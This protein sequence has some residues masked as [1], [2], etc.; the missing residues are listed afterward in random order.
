[1]MAFRDVA[2]VGIV[3]FAMGVGFLSL[4][5][6]FNT[7]VD[8]MLATS[9]INE[10]P[11]TVG[12]LG[13]VKGV[14]ERLDWVVFGIFMGLV[15]AMLVSAWFIPGHPIFMFVY[16][17]AV[18]VIVVVGAVLSNA[19]DTFSGTPPIDGSKSSFGITNNLLNNL[20]L[21]LSVVG[22]LGMII[23]FSKPGDSGGF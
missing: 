1:M 5:Y 18:L 12:V 16:F 15:L 10:S 4:H 6:M 23:L 14:T 11:S 20:P 3:V 19:W 7:S 13:A 9:E 22:F 21:Y 17:M 2:L 8:A